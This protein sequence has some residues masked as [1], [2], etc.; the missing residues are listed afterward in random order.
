ME[1]DDY[2]ALSDALWE[3]I[4]VMDPKATEEA[5]RELSNSLYD[6]GLIDGPFDD[7]EY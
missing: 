2:Q 4:E 5:L 1:Q 7:A 6:L 3:A